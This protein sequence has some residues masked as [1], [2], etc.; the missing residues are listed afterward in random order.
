M[1]KSLNTGAE[2]FVQFERGGVINRFFFSFREK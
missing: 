2:Y 1:V